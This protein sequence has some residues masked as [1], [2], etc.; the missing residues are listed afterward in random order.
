M[1]FRSRDQWFSMVRDQL[2]RDV[3]TPD[4]NTNY[5]LLLWSVYLAKYFPFLAEGIESSYERHY[6]I[7]RLSELMGKRCADVS[8]DY[9]TEIRKSP[10]R[11]IRKL[12]QIMDMTDYKKSF[13]AQ[14]SQ[15]ETDGW[16][17][18]RPPDWF[19]G[20]EEKCE[21]KLTEL[22]LV[23][24]FGIKPLSEIKHGFEASW[25][26]L[27]PVEYE[28]ML[29]KTIFLLLNARGETASAIEKINRDLNHMVATCN[30]VGENSQSV[31]DKFIEKTAGLQ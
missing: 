10:D 2:P 12:N 1:L 31:V 22:G 5:D 26:G 23:S 29:N 6:Y 24:F 7:W 13:V 21:R 28:R 4:I 19:D 15:V 17:G 27:P 8:I 16:K 18:I 30:E 9:D 11:A 14:I 25:S 3:T 20:I